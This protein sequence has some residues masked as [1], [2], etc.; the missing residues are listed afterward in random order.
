MSDLDSQGSVSPPPPEDI[1]EQSPTSMPPPKEKKK[2]K[3]KEAGPA[4]AKGTTVLPVARVGRIIKVRQSISFI[5]ATGN[6]I[7]PKQIEREV[8]EVQ[9]RVKGR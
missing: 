6:P 4:R 7:L 9:P 3:P 5:L 2:M 1:G 8:A